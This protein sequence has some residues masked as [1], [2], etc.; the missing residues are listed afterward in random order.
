V[1]SFF[2]LQVGR[3]SQLEGYMFSCCKLH[4]WQQ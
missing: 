1:A 2:P 4:L 3:Y